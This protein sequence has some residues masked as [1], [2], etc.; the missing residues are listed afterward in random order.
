MIDGFHRHAAAIRR[1]RL[2]RWASA[3]QCR[4]LL[5]GVDCRS[6]M[7]AFG[8]GKIG[9][10]QTVGMVGRWERRIFR[11]SYGAS[12]NEGESDRCGDD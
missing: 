9:Q 2:N 10:E 5:L 4:E 8:N 3:L 6:R 1:V 11:P 7:T 12:G